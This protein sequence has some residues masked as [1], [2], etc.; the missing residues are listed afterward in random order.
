MT[1]KQ[2]NNSMNSMLPRIELK[3]R[4]Q[5]RNECHTCVQSDMWVQ[6]VHINTILKV[7]VVVVCCSFFCKLYTCMCAHVLYIFIST[8]VPGYTQLYPG[9]CKVVERASHA[10]TPKP[11]W[12]IQIEHLS[13]TTIPLQHR[14]PHNCL[15]R[16]PF[17]TT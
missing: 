4:Y 7:E 8:T 17:P 10:R 11:K 16:P 9:N 13:P 12:S 1:K 3:N 2:K 5:E 14:T 6:R 15:C